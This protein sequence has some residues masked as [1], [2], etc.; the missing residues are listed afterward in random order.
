M[1]VMQTQSG[2]NRLQYYHIVL[3]HSYH[4]FLSQKTR[5]Q[6]NLLSYI[7]FYGEKID[8]HTHETF[9]CN[10]IKHIRIG[11]VRKKYLFNR[12]K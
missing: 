4:C 1:V 3:L 10:Y 9:S 11:V 8:K 12:V 5:L 6:S 2:Q 7:R